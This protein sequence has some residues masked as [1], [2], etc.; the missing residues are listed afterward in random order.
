MTTPLKTVEEIEAELSAIVD[1]A[2]NESRDLT[3]AEVGAYEAGEK[4]LADARARRERTDA[5]RAR[6]AEYKAAVTKPLFVEP[7]PEKDTLDAAF[8]HYLRTGRE[9]ADLADLRAALGE[10]T[11]SQ[12]GFLVPTT[13]RLK[14]VER[15][16]AFGGL[17][18]DVET[19]ETETG[20]T[21]E[22]PTLDDTG[23]SARIVQEG[24]GPTGGADLSFQRKTIGAYRFASGGA[25]DLPMRLPI[26]L[27]Q[28]S[29]FDIEAIVARKLG[30]RIGRKQAVSIVTGTGVGE[31][32]GITH[33][34]TGIELL[35]DTAGVTYDDL[36]NFE[37]SVDPAYRELGNCRWAFNDKS[38]AT[39]K[40]LKD[41]HGDPL[42][43][44]NTA[45]MGTPLGGGMLNGYPVRIDQAFPDIDVDNNTVNWGVFGDLRE[46]Y[47]RRVVRDVVIVVNPWTRASNGQIEYS[48][49]ARMDG[50]RQNTSS[51]IAMT[52]EQ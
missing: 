11:G 2:D 30:E 18:N 52:G 7:R 40:K 26:E 39:I 41:S 9:N 4:D 10:G 35:A 21:V 3:D 22:F 49:W 38:L 13:M 47:L 43:R 31:V 15:M 25:G 1:T 8:N 42:W 34:V 28:D 17:A 45:D 33:G 48:A 19:Y 32:E 14:L 16:V 23:N 36:I 27:V 20:N 12:G 46:G 37:H 6:H 44:P 29:A 50:I 51:Y 5:L 24:E